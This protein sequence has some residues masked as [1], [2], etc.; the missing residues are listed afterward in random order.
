MHD[1]PKVQIGQI[2]VIIEAA[3]QPAAK[4]APAPSPN[5]LASRHY[6]RRL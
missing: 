1:A 3:A 6:L 4:P 2:D 5:D